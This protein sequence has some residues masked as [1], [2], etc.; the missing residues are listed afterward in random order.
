M[1]TNIINK[2]AFEFTCKSERT[3]SIVQHNIESYTSIEFNV[4]ME[5][6]FTEA[7]Q[8]NNLLKIDKLEIDLGDVH[9][10]DISK[11]EIL[12]KFRHILKQKIIHTGTVYD[13]DKISNPNGGGYFKG[14]PEMANEIELIR[15]FMTTGDVPWW[16]DKKNELNINT[17]V[18]KLINDQPEAFKELLEEFT[19]SPKLL[20][21]LFTQIKPGIFL[22]IEK[23]HPYFHNIILK[24]R[25]AYGNIRLELNLLSARYFKKIK[26]IHRK[27]NPD[28]FEKLSQKL[29]RILL[30]IFNGSNLELLLNQPDM[31]QQ[32]S[33]EKNYLLLKAHTDKSFEKSRQNVVNILQQLL[34]AH[35]GLEP[36]VS[37][38]EIK[39][40]IT[41]QKNNPAK[42]QDKKNKVE[43][44][45]NR[46]SF[47]EKEL[48]L[49]ELSNYVKRGKKFD[50]FS[51]MSYLKSEKYFPSETI[52]TKTEEI[53]TARQHIS[54]EQ[55]ANDYD[56]TFDDKTNPLFNKTD[57][58]KEF[59]NQL[60]VKLSN[61][62]F[63]KMIVFIMKK[64]RSS[65][66]VLLQYLQQLDHAQLKQLTSLFKKR[67]E[68]AK[69][70]KQI[71]KSLLNHPFL[72]KYGIFRLLIYL[73]SYEKETSGQVAYNSIKK[74][75]KDNLPETINVK[76]QSQEPTLLSSS[77]RLPTKDF[78]IIKDILQ[79]GCFETENEKNIVK[80]ILNKLSQPDIFILKFL[81]ELPVHEIEKVLPLA[82]REYKEPD[83]FYNTD[84]QEKKIYIENA[85]LC[86]I[87]VYL[88]SFFKQL[89][90]LENGKFKN[91]QFALRAIFIIQY[92][93]S[94]KIKSHEYLLQLNKLLC[95]FQVEEPILKKIQIA[96]KEKLEAENLIESVI[97][98]WKTLKNT[99]ADGFRES[100]LQ[101]KGILY[102]NE[103]SW[104]LKVEK[105]GYDVLLE[106]LPWSYN[107]IKLP[108]MTR[109][110]QVEW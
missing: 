21:R 7:S 50:N 63:Q 71:I 16:V 98:N 101:R 62:D 5:S 4:I 70:R 32:I 106:T 56:E 14:S 42:E 108:W 67:V 31:K 36:S 109:P 65:N 30:Q 88:P 107:I 9:A 72:F 11:P 61:N 82:E 78:I 79:K 10:D 74:G 17:I 93:V 81:S 105:K 29:T 41:S 89:K 48:L 49:F 102:E 58:Q 59:S 46:L 66:I 96:K 27:N 84:I 38:P 28:L 76:D 64:L 77:K 57:N 110:I 45:V 97:Q 73:S 1:Y 85:G 15:S 52:D 24:E 80:K 6:I 104:T 95:S 91:K 22:K 13:T 53:D 68:E 34:K 87:A 75:L 33:S 37:Q 47:F 3:A 20:A 86:L 26:K 35:P 60:E 39:Q 55:A 100:F 83:E 69:E 18:Q 40:S 51:Y 54:E 90:Y 44:F 92:I 8:D 12:S 19:E 94:G 103:K 25:L 43:T 2:E 23:W 99:S